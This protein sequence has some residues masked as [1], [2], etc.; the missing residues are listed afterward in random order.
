M[1]TV[2]KTI[3][4]FE[5]GIEELEYFISSNCIQSHAL[6]LNV[7][8]NL[9]SHKMKLYTEGFISFIDSK[10]F[11]RHNNIGNREMKLSAKN[12]LIRFVINTFL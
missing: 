11:W 6:L 3:K 2:S 8:T 12:G 7:M 9:K 10:L 4:L 5:T 1:Y